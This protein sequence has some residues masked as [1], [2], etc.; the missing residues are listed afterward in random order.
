MGMTTKGNVNTSWQLLQ[1]RLNRTVLENFEPNLRFY[2]MGKKSAWKKGYNTLSRT[3][4]DRKISTPASVL[5][6]EGVT[7]TATNIT[8]TTISVTAN[9]YGEFATITD[10]LEDSSP[11]QMIKES[12]KVLGKDMARVMDSVMQANLETNWTNVIYA[13]SATSRATLGATDLMTPTLLAKANAFLSTKS[14]PTMGDAYVAVMHPNVIYDLQ[15]GASAW[16]FLDLK[17]YTDANAKD[18]MNWEIGMLYNVRVVKSAWVQSFTSTVTVYPTYVM[19]EGAYGVADLQALRTYITPRSASDSDP[20]AQRQ[21]VG[22]KV[23][24][25]SIILQQDAMTRVESA[26]TLAYTF[27]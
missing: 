7:P 4:V 19:W 23:A 10:I 27:S 13:R 20:L 15:T 8:T 16:A 18:I 21:K 3:K 12:A 26:S 14:A 9:Q 22:C 2:S 1:I 25:N 6:T 17:K 24:F 5:L 11:I